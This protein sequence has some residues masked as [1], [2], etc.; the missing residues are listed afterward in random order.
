MDFSTF[1]APYAPNTV[2]SRFNVSHP[3]KA[4][5]VVINIELPG[6]EQP[7]P[8]M[9][10]L[11]ALGKRLPQLTRYLVPGSRVAPRGMC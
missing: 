11:F 8:R 7:Q 5:H 6:A 2:Y 3:L 9:S 1:N 4:W 10:R